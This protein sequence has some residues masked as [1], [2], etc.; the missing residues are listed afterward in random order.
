MQMAKLE[1]QIRRPPFRKVGRSVALSPAGEELLGYARRIL[2]LSEEALARFQ[3]DGLSGAVR[4]GVTDDYE[5]LLLPAVLARFVRLHPDADIEVVH[6][7][8]LALV[9]QT[10]ANEVDLALVEHNRTRSLV[11]AGEVIHAEPFVWIGRRG[12]TASAR[13][14]LPIAVPGSGCFWRHTALEALDRAA[15]PYRIAFSCEYSHGQVAAIEAD[16]AVAPLP[17]RYLTGTLERVPA[18]EALPDLGVV[19]TSLCVAPGASDLA[20]ALA[21]VVRQTLARREVA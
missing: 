20:R 13:R 10:A 21:E 14:P 17:A 16:L 2:S 4:F 19:T 1:E 8:S 18:S 7:P 15:I 11:A 9:E 6:A 3:T 12:G 5:T